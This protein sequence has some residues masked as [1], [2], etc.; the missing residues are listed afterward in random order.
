METTRMTKEQAGELT[1]EMNKK[2]KEFKRKIEDLK[3]ETAQKLKAA[4]YVWELKIDELEA[5]FF[6]FYEKKDAMVCA[7]KVKE[8]GLTPKVDKTQFGQSG[9]DIDMDSIYYVDY[10]SIDEVIELCKINKCQGAPCNKKQRIY[11]EDECDDDDEEYDEYDDDEEDD[12][13]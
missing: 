13:N 2:I 8:L 6:L 4:F 5:D 12:E 10:K 11:V 7:E 3:E 9:N 1:N